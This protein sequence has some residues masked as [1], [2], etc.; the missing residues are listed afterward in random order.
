MAY[1]FEFTTA[2]VS[3]IEHLTEMTPSG[4]IKHTIIVHESPTLEQCLLRTCQLGLMNEDTF[5]WDSSVSKELISI[6]VDLYNEFVGEAAHWT[7][8]EK[9]WGIKDLRK[10]FN[11][12]MGRVGYWEKRQAMMTCFENLDSTKGDITSKR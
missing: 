9:R 8:A 10:Y 4:D 3:S 12:A 11:K 5:E 7:W 1:K 2:V 6:W